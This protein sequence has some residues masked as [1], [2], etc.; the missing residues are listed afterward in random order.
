MI[1]YRS[2]AF[3]LAVLKYGKL[4]ISSCKCEVQTS[5]SQGKLLLACLCMYE[6][7]KDTE[8]EREGGRRLSCV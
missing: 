2:V 6:R 4:R 5:V 1:I 8:R 3:T 7:E